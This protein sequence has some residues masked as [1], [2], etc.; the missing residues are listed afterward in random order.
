MRAWLSRCLGGIRNK[1]AVLLGPVDPAEMR[2][3]SLVTTLAMA[4]FIGARFLGSA[5]QVVWLIAAMAY[6][7]ILLTL[8]AYHVLG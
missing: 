6:V 4:A 7:G 1:P 8:I 3:A 5:G 2:V